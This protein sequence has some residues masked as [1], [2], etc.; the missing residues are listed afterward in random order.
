MVTVFYFLVFLL[1][2]IV[3]GRVL[4]RNKS[5]D[6]VYILFCILVTTNCM[7][8]YMLASAETLET[9]IWA[10]RFQYVGGS[11]APLLTVFILSRLCSVKMPKW[12]MAFLTVYSSVIMG[13]AFT[14]GRSDLYYRHIVLKQGDGFHYLEKTYGPFH[15]LY[16]VMMV[17]YAGVMIFYM[18]VALTKRKKGGTR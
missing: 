3:T 17:L 11:Y 18:V 2:L 14:I 16:P 15:A 6:T 12:L 4:I 7:G 5:V 1:A 9:A 13:F 10:Q 8:R